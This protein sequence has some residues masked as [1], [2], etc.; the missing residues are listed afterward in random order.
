LWTTV[1]GT[2][3][4]VGIATAVSL[5]SVAIVI[6]TGLALRGLWRRAPPRM[7]HG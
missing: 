5:L 6:G 1:P 3:V 7:A 4:N 2:G